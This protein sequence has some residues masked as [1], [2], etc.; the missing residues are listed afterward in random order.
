MRL[1]SLPFFVP[2]AL[3]TAG[4]ARAGFRLDH[5]PHAHAGRLPREAHGNR[6]R[7]RD[8]GRRDRDDSLRREERRQFD[9]QRASIDVS[10]IDTREPKPGRPPQSRPTS[11]TS[12]SFPTA[13][14]FNP[15]R[16]SRSPPGKL[17]PCT[18]NLTMHGVTKPVVLDVDGP[19]DPAK[20]PYGNMKVAATGTTKIV[21][22]DFG[23]TWNK[24]LDKGGL[25]VGND[26]AVTLDIE[27]GPK[28]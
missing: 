10:Q 19:S 8:A 17:R 7:G 6:Q 20:D 3:S 16:S 5:R 15:P 9:D 1:R 2:A 14:R 22:S 25:L 11:S 27:A 13:T 24:T 12:R 23:L 4:D 28:K 26:V 18:G 21:R